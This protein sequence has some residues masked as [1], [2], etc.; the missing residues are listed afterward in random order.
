MTKNSGVV[1]VRNDGVRV[2]IQRSILFSILFVFILLPVFFM[3]FNMKG[4]DFSFV[5]SDKSF[6]LSVLNSF[7]YSFASAGISLILSTLAAY[8]LSRMR[9]RFKTAWVLILTTPML[10]P[11]LSIGLGI[12]SLFGT[13]G[14]FDQVFHV[15]FDGLGW[16][17]LIVGSVISCFPV[18]FLLVYDAMRYENK[19]VYDAANTLGI[20]RKNSFFGV[21]IP[22]LK[23]PLISA[24]F[25]AFTW[26]F[27]DYGV[28]MEVAGKIKTLP[29][30]LYEQVLTQYEYGRGA[31]VGMV[32]LIPAFG[33]FI[34]DLFSKENTS[35]EQASQITKP[36]K[37][38]NHFS[39]AFLIILSILIILPQLS[40]II[41]AFVNSFP[42]DMTLSFSH[43][44]SAFSSNAGLGV[45][46]YWLN[47]LLISFLS[48]VVGTIFSYLAAY[49]STRFSGWLGKAL[50]FL[51]LASLA[52]PGLVFGLGY[53]F[54]FKF[55]KG[56][57]Y[58]TIAILVVVN[59]VHFFATPYLMAK[60]AFS[61]LNKDYE[62]V[63]ST[64]GISRWKIFFH[65]L[66]PNTSAT[67]VEMFSFFFINSMITISAVAFLC[68]YL[69]QPLSILINTYDKQGSYE[70]QAVVSFIIL[71]TNVFAKAV[72]TV[73][74]KF[75]HKKTDKGEEE[76][77]ELTRYQFD[78]LTFLEERGPAQFTQR[79][80]SDAL[81][82]SI[83]L[84]NKMVKEY[85]ANGIIQISGDKTISLTEKGLK[86]IEP[87]KVRK[88]IIIAAGFG[89]RMAPVTL[90][91]PKPLV[92]VNGTRILDT[93]LDALY[94]KGIKTIYI[95]RGYK[96]E[97]FD[98]LLDK[99]PTVKF[100]ENPLY[101]ESNNISSIY[102]AKDLID[103][104][105]ICEADLIVSNP[106][107]ITKYQYTTNY[108]ST[109]VKET[110]DWCFW[111]KGIYINK[112]GIGGENVEQMIGISYWN[113]KDSAKL[114][115][116]VAKVFDSRGGKEN[117]W[118]NVPLK[119]CKKDFKIEI[120]ECERK[121]VTE[122]DNYSELTVIDP[123]YLKY[124][125]H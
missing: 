22:Y 106:A 84:V 50:H 100:I 91:T 35:D 26:V 6:H 111:M 118:D 36:S 77:M 90:D 28:P 15:S 45:G 25:A 57:F 23:I 115:E 70:M 95:V 109:Y 116:D 12:R 38:F 67:I 5:F 58:G 122:I 76:N 2:N 101:N 71:V 123:S 98:A 44:I 14:F 55:S 29:I 79:Q 4:A 40:F 103:R 93:L 34:V 121:D 61:K 33:A 65:V 43:F 53:V 24:F 75:L 110:D 30:Y 9:V 89:S 113:E 10:I 32:L 119:I 80:L 13:N 3:L 87:Y 120:R 20:S 64:M 112:V 69:D 66:V 99:Y 108:L 1:P 96:G 8:G 72:L 21:T 18:T 52:V 94:A 7:I 11:T 102:M 81:T 51:S 85:Q 48:G 59:S 49:Y 97:Q 73:G 46:K 82:V 27:S 78:F 68:T 60:N 86:L 42:L 16:F 19:S 17:G 47:S 83:G 31:I 107:V 117:Y 114:R 62:T 56:W 63:G 92:K 54:L 39:L 41:L 74:S 88:A 124:H 125:S 104:C 37:L 105:Y